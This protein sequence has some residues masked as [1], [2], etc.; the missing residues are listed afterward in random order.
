MST[1]DAQV[2]PFRVLKFGGTS[3][4]GAERIDVIARILGERERESVPV[5]VVSA[6][7][8]VTSTLL[9]AAR[10][11]ERG[12][13][14]CQLRQIVE[15]HQTL[16]CE[17]LRV[18]TASAIL[19][20]SKQSDEL[21]RLLRGVELLGESSPR[22]LDLILSFGERLAALIIAQALAAR[23]VRAQACDARALIVTDDH[24]GEAA[25]D[26]AATEQ[27][28]RRHFATAR[29]LQVVTG[30]IA[31]TSNGATVIM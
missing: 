8:G 6:F 19:P 18:A 7:Q 1:T 2:K 22:T 25:V 24:F 10:A 30:F 27:A 17:L 29:E 31:A 16:A 26:T 4:T 20:L 5:V 13:W 21:A 15:R 9:E 28:V 14:Q 23:G 12:E 3:V 11:S